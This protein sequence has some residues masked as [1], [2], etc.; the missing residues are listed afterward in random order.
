MIE[1]W[2]CICY[3]FILVGLYLCLWLVDGVNFGMWSVECFEE[4][5]V[6]VFVD[7]VKVVVV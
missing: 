5:I 4:I 1:K 3:F 7:F 6:G 2:L